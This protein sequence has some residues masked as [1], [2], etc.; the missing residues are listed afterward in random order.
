MRETLK[1]DSYDNVQCFQLY[2]YTVN[3]DQVFNLIKLIFKTL[4][5]NIQNFAWLNYQ[6]LLLCE[7]IQSLVKMYLCVSYYQSSTEQLFYYLLKMSHQSCLFFFDSL[8]LIQCQ[9]KICGQFTLQQAWTSSGL[10]QLEDIEYLRIC[11]M[12]EKL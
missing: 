11:Q 10:L 4:T 8:A 1:Y 7:I 9:H 3:L 6:L 5:Q 2:T 12:G